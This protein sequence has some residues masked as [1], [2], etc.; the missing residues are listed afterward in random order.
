MMATMKRSKRMPRQK[1]MRRDVLTRGLKSMTFGVMP[2]YSQFEADIRDID[3]DEGR[4]FLAHGQKYPIEC[5]AGSED[6][7][8]LQ[9]AGAKSTGYG[10]YGKLK[11]VLS[12]KQL[13]N[14]IKKL[15]DDY[16]NEEAQ[17]LASS[18]M[19]TLGYEWV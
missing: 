1:K 18:M 6:C 14:T 12:D 4:P 5:H 11:F 15:G 3:R 10:D 7:R 16:D 9:R 19:Q 13:Y 17:S 8:S 2:P